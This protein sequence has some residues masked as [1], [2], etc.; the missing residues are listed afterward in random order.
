MLVVSGAGAL[1]GGA[2]RVVGEGFSAI[3]KASGGVADLAKDAVAQNTAALSSMVDE[4]A[5]TRRAKN[6]GVGVSAAQR[7]VGIAVRKLFREGGDFRSA[8]NRAPVVRALTEA[9]MSPA[10]ANQTVERWSNSVQ[11]MRAD[12]EEAKAA[13]ALKAREAAEKAAK[14]MAHAA[15]WAFIGFVLGALSAMWGGAAGARWEYRHAPT[16][17]PILNTSGGRVARHA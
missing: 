13:A 1:V 8:D 6:N 15:L 9:G 12:L 11:Q 16:R 2:S 3:G 4:V 10:D 17:S 14:A 5:E 7:D